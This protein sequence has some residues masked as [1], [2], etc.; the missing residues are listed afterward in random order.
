MDWRV[1]VYGR[2]GWLCSRST[3]AMIHEQIEKLEELQKQLA[4]ARAI[5]VR[6]LKGP[7]RESAADGLKTVREIGE[8][9]MAEGVQGALH[10]AQTSFEADGTELGTAGRRAKRKPR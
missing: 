7:K 9:S 2:D 10:Q 8:A 4:Q 3:L 6:L 5:P 1:R